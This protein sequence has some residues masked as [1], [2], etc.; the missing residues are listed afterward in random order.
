MGLKSEVRLSGSDAILRAELTA[1]EL[2]GGL[3]RDLGRVLGYTV[4]RIETEVY[5]KEETTRPQM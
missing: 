4:G 5:S 1:G 2:A 3:K